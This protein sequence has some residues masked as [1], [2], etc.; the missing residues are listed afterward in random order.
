MSQ[1]AQEAQGWCGPPRP[2]RN[3]LS[4]REFGTFVSLTGRFRCPR[5][6]RFGR[7]REAPSSHN[8]ARVRKSAETP[9]RWRLGSSTTRSGSDPRVSC[10]PSRASAYYLFLPEQ[11]KAQEELERA[12][13]AERLMKEAVHRVRRPPR[14][15]RRVLGRGGSGVCSE[16]RR[17]M[18]GWP[19]RRNAGSYEY[20]R[21]PTDHLAWSWLHTSVVRRK[22]RRARIPSE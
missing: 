11:R 6:E 15:P 13:N 22:G 18:Q 2:D 12:A 16:G 7:G 17:I 9:A 21:C 20:I 10:G 1:N 3:R 4:G 19:G 5:H 8:A 14:R